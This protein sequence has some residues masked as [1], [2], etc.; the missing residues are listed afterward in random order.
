MY[1]EVKHNSDKES[2]SSVKQNLVNTQRDNQEESEYNQMYSWKVIEGTSGLVTLI[3]CY[4]RGRAKKS[5][6]L[7]VSK[8]LVIYHIILSNEKKWYVECLD[9]GAKRTD[10]GLWK[11]QDFCKFMNTELKS[12]KSFNK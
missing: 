1:Q 8:I 7:F 5:K 6:L 12:E 4:I 10:T 2:Q 11:A 3:L 9:T